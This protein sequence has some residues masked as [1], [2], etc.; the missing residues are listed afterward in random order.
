MNVK[1]SRF[2]AFLKEEDITLFERKDFEDEDGTVVYRSYIKS[3]LWDMPLFVIT[4]NTIFTVIRL[5][6]APEKVAPHHMEALNRFVHEQNST[7][8][9][10]KVYVEEEDHTLYVDCVYIAADDAFEPALVY[11][12]MTNFVDYV[13][14]V[15]KQLHQI[16][17]TPEV[18]GV[19]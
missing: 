16:F 14:A 10:F 13:P 8:K 2:D 11:A 3:P 18:G 15:V 7:Y 12:L 5:V 19:N 17:T 6:M 1:A 9:T 4:D